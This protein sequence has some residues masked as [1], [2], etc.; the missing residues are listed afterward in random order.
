MNI[1]LGTF[2]HITY[3]VNLIDCQWD[4]S[5]KVPKAFLKMRFRLQNHLQSLEK[6]TPSFILDMA[7]LRKRS[8]VMLML[9]QWRVH[10]ATGISWEKSCYGWLTTSLRLIGVYTPF[11]EHNCKTKSPPKKTKVMNLPKSFEEIG[12][13]LLL[14]IVCCVCMGRQTTQTE[15]RSQKVVETKSSSQC[16]QYDAGQN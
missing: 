16:A 13:W 15:N 8:L 2:E 11:S 14:I 6:L 9:L 4:L 1:Y 12:R 3:Y 10:N 5:T 7:Y